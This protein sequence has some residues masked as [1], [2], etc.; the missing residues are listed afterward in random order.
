[1]TLVSLTVY[2]RNGVETCIFKPLPTAAAAVL[3]SHGR[4]PGGVENTMNNVVNNVNNM[5][6]MVDVPAGAKHWCKQLKCFP[7]MDAP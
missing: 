5:G 7:T 3:N 1:M 4:R 6:D 2:V